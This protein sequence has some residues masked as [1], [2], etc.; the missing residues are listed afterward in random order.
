VSLQ[1]RLE[2]LITAIGADIKVLQSRG[3]PTGGSAGQFLRKTSAA[4]YDTGWAVVPIPPKTFRTGHTWLVAGAITAAPLPP[5]FVPSIGGAQSLSLVA[6]RAQILSGTNVTV[7]M[8]HNGA[9][10]QS[11]ITVTTT[12]VTTVF[13]QTMTDLDRLGVVLS[14]PTGSPADLSITAILEHVI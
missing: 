13:V 1:S 7:Q 14:A 2:A 3:L 9:N 5:I 12:P 11:A 10:L 4:N 6:V 8:Q